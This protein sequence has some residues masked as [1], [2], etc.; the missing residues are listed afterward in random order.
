MHP[1]IV[2][3]YEVGHADGIHFI[4]QEFVA[5]KSLD[6]ILAHKGA[7][8]QGVV[9]DILRQVAFAL[10]KA[11]EVGIVHRDIKPANIFILANGQAKVGDFGIARIESSNLT[12]AGSVLGTPAYMSPEQFMGQRIDGRSDLFSAGVI[13]Y[14]FLSGEKPFAGQLTTIMHKVLKEDPIAPSELNVQVPA[15][16]DAV[17][18][19]A[20]AKR[21]DDRYQTARAFADALQAALNNRSAADSEATLVGSTPAAAEETL[22]RPEPAK[23]APA[24]P[25]PM[26]PSLGE[27][28][29]SQVGPIGRQVKPGA[30][31]SVFLPVAAVVGAALVIFASAAIYFIKKDKA[32]ADTPSHAAASLPAQTAGDESAPKTMTISAVA[33]ADP[34]DPRFAGDPALM[35][36]TLREE[37]RRELVEKAVALYVQPA[38]MSDHYALLRDKL[39]Q[40]SGDFIAAVI[41]EDAPQTGKDGLVSMSTKATVR[42]RDVQKSLNQMSQDERVDFIRNNGDPKI[43]V[44]ITTA[45]SA[46]E[47]PPRRSPV[48]ENLLKEKIQ[49]FGF[50]TWAEDGGNKKADFSVQ[51]EAKF[52]KLS[53]KLEASGL[54]IERTV[55]TSWTIKCID[56]RSGEEIYFNTTIPK[57]KS[58]N[59][60]DEAL[61]DVGKLIGEEFSKS[62]FLQNY[63]FIG[64]KVR[65]KLA[66]LP[67][68]QFGKRLSTEVSGLRNVL[69]VKPIES[70]LLEVDL[71]GG[72]T[73]LSDLVTTG[74]TTPLN[75]KFGRACFNVAS[76]FENEVRVDFSP[77]CSDQAIAAR[78]D[79]APPA[80][81][82]AAP[83]P[84]V[85][86][87]V[88]NPELR[89]KLQI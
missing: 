24:S 39:L 13:L 34:S 16:F 8:D 41:Q 32:S 40:R 80:A 74:I 58:W 61:A 68:S 42:I 52:K 88:K 53:V 9:L 23:P 56:K 60:E 18:R 85:E 89:K 12:Q 22:I 55:I 47:A 11:A 45:A 77:E 69:A 29:E 33:Y 21:P 1:N 25:P 44:V 75:R 17:V 38:S 51:G 70:D 84:K 35:R 30:K 28:I 67:D 31:R 6:E 19:K 54:Q 66:G 14:Q 73:N 36:A 50:R 2:Q 5:G 43:S 65:L 7:L 27:M 64:Q 46:E 26:P 78:L 10:C 79:T 72:Q 62:F 4:A 37:S 86:A 57:G 48:A 83:A 63:H 20:M 81:L 82:F 87:I 3:I 15:A 76:T 59:S 71:S 49:S